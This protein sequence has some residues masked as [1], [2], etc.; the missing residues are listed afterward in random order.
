[1]AKSK[2]V[3]TP[4]AISDD[5]WQVEGALRTLQRAGEI[6]HDKKLMVRVKAMASEKAVEMTAIAKQ[7]SALAKSGRISPKQMAKLAAR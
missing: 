7:A 4:T 5:H 6:V 2:A 3:S 1:M